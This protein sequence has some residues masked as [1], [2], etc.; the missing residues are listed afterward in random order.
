VFTSRCSQFPQNNYYDLYD[1]M[2]NYM[3]D[4]KNVDERGYNITGKP[5]LGSC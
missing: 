4:D 1:L 5:D 3:G 2:K